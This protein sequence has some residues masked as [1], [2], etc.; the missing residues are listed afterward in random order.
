MNAENIVAKRTLQLHFDA[1]K[2]EY[3]DLEER[4]R[5]IIHPKGEDQ[6]LFAIGANHRMYRERI[7]QRN[8]VLRDAL[9]SRRSRLAQLG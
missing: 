2:E 3:A 6:P 1:A 7:A 4:T 8:A 9:A 5:E